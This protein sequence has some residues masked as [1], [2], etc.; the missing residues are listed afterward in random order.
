MIILLN[1]IYI[2]K[3][4]V[5]FTILINNFIMTYTILFQNIFNCTIFFSILV[6]LKYLLFLQIRQAYIP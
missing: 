4:N 2:V 3:K 5:N 6:I 1:K